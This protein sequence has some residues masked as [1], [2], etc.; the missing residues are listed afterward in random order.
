MTPSVSARWMHGKL[1]VAQTI[2]AAI[3]LQI[4]SFDETEPAKLVEKA[5]VGDAAIFSEG[6]IMPRR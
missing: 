5:K 2:A 1:L 4:L 3:N 6:V